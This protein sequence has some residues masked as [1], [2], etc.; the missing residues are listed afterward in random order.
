MP[1]YKGSEGRSGRS[2]IIEQLAEVSTLRGPIEAH[3]EV[4]EDN[5]NLLDAFICALVAR[6]WH[7]G[8]TYLPDEAAVELMGT[9]CPDWF[10][11]LHFYG[12]VVREGWIAHPSTDLHDALSD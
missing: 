1:P 11:E 9:H 3:R 8:H 2:H 10:D 6:S 4:L 12:E 5:D 7:R